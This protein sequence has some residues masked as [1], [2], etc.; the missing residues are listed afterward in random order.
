MPEPRS[1]RHPLFLRLTKPIDPVYPDAV[2]PVAWDDDECYE[3]VRG[4]V[5]IVTRQCARMRAWARQLRKLHD[6]D[7]TYKTEEGIS[8]LSAA[9]MRE[10]NL[11]GL[12][13]SVDLYTE[14]GGEVIAARSAVRAYVATDLLA[15]VTDRAGGGAVGFVSFGLKW[16]ADAFAGMD[17]EVEL[18]VELDQAWMDP[19]F[20]RRGWGELAVIAIALATKRHIDQVHETTRWPRGFF[21][22]LKLTVC[23][24]LYSTSGE[25]LLAKCADYVA[26]EF[27][28]G[29]ELQ[30]LQ[31]SQIMLD[32]RW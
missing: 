2:T 22:Q 1:R 13:T 17:D 4:V 7:E 29:A 21:A 32:G 23:A 26:L 12:G 16:I 6:A 30:R 11:R 3:N 31:V 28:L 5:Y 25:A 19:A 8:P 27:G 10:A 9:P 18:E 14:H 15:V 20:R 24:D